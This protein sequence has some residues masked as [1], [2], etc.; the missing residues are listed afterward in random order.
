M[1]SIL[2][3]RIIV[4]VVGAVLILFAGNSIKNSLAGRE[5]PVRQMSFK[6]SAKIVKAAPVEYKTREIALS[7]I[8]K[9][10][11]ESAIDLAAEVQGEILRGDVP[12]KQAT[13]F[14]KGTV[15]FRIDDEEARL[16]LFAQKSNFMTAI[17]NILPD[18][19]I[20]YPNSYP[21]W[22]E[23]FNQLS[24]EKP[25]PDLPPIKDSQEKVFFSTRNINNQFYTIKSSEE[26][27]TKYEVRAPFSGSF[28]EVLQEENSAVNP[29]ARIARIA[30]SSSLEVEVP[31]RTNDLSY[32][33]SGTTVTILPET[34]NK[35][36][37]GIVRRIG[38]SVD[39]TTQ[40]VNV[41]VSLRNN[42]EKVYEGQYLRVE[43]PGTRLKDV[44]E[45]PRNAVFNRNQVYVVAD[46]SELKVKDI[47]IEKLKDESVLF[48][49]LEA[50]EMVV[51]QPLV[52]AY[53]NMPVSLDG[54]NE[55]PQGAPGGKPK[56]TQASS[57]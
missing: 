31:I 24:V 17:A 46:S 48:S 32:V 15:L 8:G 29:G 26:R 7:A 42:G 41:F 1:D 36:W 27:L 54:A 14:S 6:E 21:Q 9:V 5:I 53:P 4:S 56:S 45:I 22:Q 2:L 33:R 51:I 11:S 55:K 43:I 16:S 34:G 12:L 39:P 52:N 44:M 38:S 47:Q 13:R 49:G 28:I 23:Y 19:K 35:E 37:K 30:R 18:L 25:L 40:S 10:I 57:N 3:R 20:D 50:G